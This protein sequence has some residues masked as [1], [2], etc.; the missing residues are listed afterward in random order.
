MSAP[1]A[2][3]RSGFRGFV[4]ELPA[5]G[6]WLLSTVVLQFFGR[7]L[8]LPFTIIYL[9]EVRGFDLGLAGTLLGIIAVVGLVVTGPAGTVIDRYGARLVILGGLVCA[10]AG[11]LLLAFATVPVVAAV[12]LVLI[13]VNM[14]VSWP[15][16]NA[17][18]ATVVAGETR[19]RYY[20][21]NF[22]LINLGI[23]VGGVVGGFMVDVARP[24]TFTLAFVV[25]GLT[26][27]LPVLVLA[28]PLRHVHG[29]AVHP[30]GAAAAA[31]PASYL[32]ILR[33][34]EVTWLAVTGMLLAGL[35]YGQIESGFPAFGRQVSE[36]STRIV[37][38]AFVVNTA[39]IVACQFW[40][41]GKV[42]GRR[43]T[44]GLIGTAAV[45]ATAWVVLGATGL[46]PGG[47]AAAAGVLAFQAVF[48][49]GEIL[50]Q[51]AFPALTNDMAPDHLRGRYNAINA[52]SF[53]IGA[54]LGPI[55]AGNLLA[56]HLGGAFIALMCVGS[57]C[58]ALGAL[59]IERR[60][61]LAVNGVRERHDEVTL[62]R[63]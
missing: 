19:Q 58:I 25:N 23:G 4:A 46:A 38:F 27:A 28:G 62:V 3:S 40:V 14:G 61:T 41:M 37:G 21:L 22:A 12:A 44:R 16:A 1:R 9:H 35:G 56:H 63:G 13:G 60:V 51:T 48:G 6:R 18:V 59:A 55:A 53:Q 7:G 32:T 2:G 36:V 29:R 42:S 50:M 10:V 30:A 34:P 57:G 24:W 33:R 20:G 26:F 49:A 39:L 54:I 8:T 45:W 31:A 5:E 47:I 43:R 15:A 17:M 11:D 52:G